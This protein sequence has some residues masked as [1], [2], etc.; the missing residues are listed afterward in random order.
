ML[1]FLARRRDDA[2]GRCLLFRPDA[3]LA[4]K[5]RERGIGH[6]QQLAFL[7]QPFAEL[8]PHPH[9]V[10]LSPLVA[11]FLMQ[12][13][14]GLQVFV[15]NAASLRRRRLGA[16]AGQDRPHAVAAD[17]QCLRDLPLAA[18]FGR[19]GQDSSPGL[20]IQH[21]L[22]PAPRR[23]RPQRP[24]L[25]SSPATGSARRPAAMP[26]AAVAAYPPACRCPPPPAGCAQ[27][28]TKCCR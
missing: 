8:L 14:D 22:P 7:A 28:P 20:F 6:L 4:A 27:V 24:P 2:P 26:A 3:A 21:E 1:H 11:A 5:P 9:E 10:C 13:L 18:L 23:P 15:Q 19:Q 12:G 16:A 25:P 17:L